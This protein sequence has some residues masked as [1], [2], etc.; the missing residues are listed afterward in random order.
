MATTYPR[1]MLYIPNE[2]ADW[3]QDLAKHL[4][5][6]DFPIQPAPVKFPFSPPMM[7]GQGPD[8][9]AHFICYPMEPVK[10]AAN[11]L[12]MAPRATS[13]GAHS[14]SAK[15][16]TDLALH[17]EATKLGKITRCYELWDRSVAF[18]LGEG[19]TLANGYLD[20]TLTQVNERRSI[21]TEPPNIADNDVPPLTIC[22]WD[23]AHQALIPLPSPGTQTQFICA[24]YEHWCSQRRRP[25]VMVNSEPSIRA[26]FHDQFLA[27]I[28]LWMRVRLFPFDV[29]LFDRLN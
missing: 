1:P 29:F 18:A 10:F 23:A 9:P 26:E 27:P 17:S 11:Q 28:E 7:Y 5:S 21:T 4:D 16:V 15:A 19:Q 24:L 22:A 13:V 8:D 12:I 25:V 14:H 3:R 6:T 2:C 20:P